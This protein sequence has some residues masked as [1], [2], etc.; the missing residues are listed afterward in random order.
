MASSFPPTPGRLDDSAGSGTS[1]FQTLRRV[2]SRVL[3]L[4][5]ILALLV[6]VF[7]AVRGNSSSSPMR[8][9]TTAAG[10]P[11]TQRAA[12]TSTPTPGHVSTAPDFTLPTLAG[13]TF[14]LAA[15]RGH[16]VV[17][18]FMA[19]G[20]AGCEPGSTALAESL[21]SAHIQGAEALAIDVSGSDRSADLEAF[22]QSLGISASAPVQWGI[23]TTG[24]ITNAYGVQVLETTVI[25]DPQGRVA[26]RNN[27]SV[28]SA[29][30]TQIVRNLA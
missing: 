22:V 5:V 10:I 3:V 24:A 13:T 23:D 4:A 21:A 15:Q 19:T 20:C 28:P 9:N 18:Y 8:G 2:G 17:L 25:I 12:G 16:V 26:Y 30:L 14:H 29:Q 6:G 11:S 1:P 7:V 27:G